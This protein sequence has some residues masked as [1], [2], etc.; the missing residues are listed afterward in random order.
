MQKKTPEGK[1]IFVQEIDKDVM[2]YP[3]HHLREFYW[4]A[5][6][7]LDRPLSPISRGWREERLEREI[8]S[9]HK[10]LD[11]PVERVLKVDAH[12]TPDDGSG[13]R[14]T[15]GDLADLLH[16]VD[17]ITLNRI[18]DKDKGNNKFVRRALDIMSKAGVKLF[19]RA[20]LSDFD[21]CINF[22]HV[23]K[24]NVHIPPPD[25]S[26]HT[27]LEKEARTRVIF[28]QLEI[29]VVFRDIEEKKALFELLISASNQTRL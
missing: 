28:E 26:I 24:K 7:K 15:D 17:I 19:E 11:N 23:H 13:Q 25:T 16:P 14:I 10:T 27:E 29:S 2:M 5:E 8:K 12:S 21:L 3:E 9:I 1:T 4:S 22:D 20:T 6:D 18:Y